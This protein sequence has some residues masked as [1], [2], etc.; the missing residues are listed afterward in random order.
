MKLP[1]SEEEYKKKK[2]SHEILVPGDLCYCKGPYNPLDGWMVVIEGNYMDIYSNL[3]PYNSVADTYQLNQYAG[4]SYHD[5]FKSDREVMIV[6]E[7]AWYYRHDLTYIRHLNKTEYG[8]I[9]ALAEAGTEVPKEI[10]D[11]I[12]KVKREYLD[13]YIGQT[14]GLTRVNFIDVDNNTTIG[15]ILEKLPGNMKIHIDNIHSENVQTLQRYI[16]YIVDPNTM[17]IENTKDGRTLLHLQFTREI[18]HDKPSHDDDKPKQ[19]DRK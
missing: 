6:E 1:F 10:A 18:R 11:A 3:Y 5:D 2:K 4:F 14:E 19:E 12:F 16:N 13:K 15:M 17:Y 9:K 8:T 7:G